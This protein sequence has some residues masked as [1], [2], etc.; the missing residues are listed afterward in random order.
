MSRYPDR[1]D[2]CLSTQIGGNSRIGSAKVVWSTMFKSLDLVR[3]A[4]LG[5]WAN[6][7][8]M[9]PVVGV[10]DRLATSSHS[11]TH[12]R[13]RLKEG[14]FHGRRIMFDD[15]N[16]SNPIMIKDVEVNENSASTHTRSQRPG[17]T[18][19]NYQQ[20]GLYSYDSY[21]EISQFQVRQSARQCPM[22]FTDILYPLVGSG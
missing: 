22:K 1:R 12:I 18:D 3:L 16:M 11:L 21:P 17:Y 5:C 9:V 8:S 13:D 7:I 4:G 15:R 10:P 6:T 2:S 20:T 19:P 14:V